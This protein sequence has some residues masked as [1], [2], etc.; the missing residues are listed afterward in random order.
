MQQAIQRA[1]LYSPAVRARIGG[2]E[3]SASSLSIER[4]LPDPLAG[5]SLTAAT[6]SLVVAEGD[7]LTTTVATPWDPG[8]SWPPVPETSATIEMSTGAGMVSAL[9]DGRVMAASGGTGT[10]DVQVEVADRYQSLD[11]TISW[12]ALSDVMPSLEDAEYGRYVGLRA[13]AVTD[14][15]LRHCGWY[16]TPPMLSYCV[17]SVPAMGT[18]W[19]ERGECL[20]VLNGAGTGYPGWF[21]EPWGAGVT[22]VYATYRNSV[23]GYTIKDQGRVELT[24]IA[25]R[26]NGGVSRLDA[27]A[28]AQPILGASPRIRLGWTDDYAYVAVTSPDGTHS[29]VASLPRSVGSLLYATVRYDTDNSVDVFLRVDGQVAEALAVPVDPRITTTGVAY[30]RIAGDGVGGG[31][32]VALPTTSGTLGSWNSNAVIYE[33]A[34]SANTLRMVPAMEGGNV[35]DLLAQQCEAQCATYWIDETGVLRWWDLARLEGQSSVATLHSDEDITADGFTWSHD[36]SSVKS[37]AL[38]KWVEP[39]RE[40]GWRTT[41]EFWRGSGAQVDPDDEPTESWINVP[42]DEVWIMPDLSLHRVGTADPGETF[43]YGIGSHYGGVY[44]QEAGD[45]WALS[46]NVV[47]ERVNDTAFK[48]Y[49]SAD[50]GAGDRIIQRTADGPGGLWSWRRGVD[51]PVIRGRMKY[52]LSDRATYSTQSGPSSAPE[53]EID[54]GWWIQNAEQARY[55]ADYAGARVTIPQPILSSIAII[56]TP[57]LQIG[58]VVTVHDTTVTRLTIRGLVIDDA[59]DIDADMGIGHAVAVRP[60]YVTRNGFTWQDWASVVRDEMHAEWAADWED[61][62]WQEWA[63]EPLH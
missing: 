41:V 23:V 42:T 24:A 34:A 60:T 35:A 52:M 18:L 10:R 43:N 38:V 36:L 56:P 59:R 14:R 32:Q 54:A 6:G 31:F 22:D 15:M 12:D 47:I 62:Q 39:L 3:V 11:K 19:P 29:S 25:G 44:N 2:R 8:T 21:T 16:A 50:A 53:H 20:S 1:D 7:D 58:D 5:D 45:E 4:S 26:T 33:R 30:T 48:L 40:Y 49:T 57:G 17:L 55:T 13:V 27:I 46:L 61:Q 9:R 28:D 51:L 37:R 63:E